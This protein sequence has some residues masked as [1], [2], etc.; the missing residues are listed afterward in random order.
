MGTQ[1]NKKNGLGSAQRLSISSHNMHSVTLRVRRR[2][3][4]FHFD[5]SRVITKLFI[6]GDAD[7]IRH[8][9]NRVLRLSDIDVEHILQELKLN[10]EARH[11]DIWEVFR[12]H[13][14]QVR[15]LGYSSASTLIMNRLKF[16][17]QKLSKCPNMLR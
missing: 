15:H 17:G 8:V 4:T 13:F 16:G 3:E 11:K 5:S 12:E 10:F 6:P 1:R 2:E 7:R 14:E 9:V